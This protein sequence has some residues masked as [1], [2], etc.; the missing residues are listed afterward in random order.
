MLCRM[1]FFLNFNRKSS[2]GFTLPAW[3]TKPGPV[4]LRN[5]VRAN[6]N[7]DH[8]CQVQLT[9]ANPILRGSDFLTAMNLP[10]VIARFSPLPLVLL[11]ISLKVWK[12]NGD[13]HQ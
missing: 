4:L 6:K 1:N 5:I 12:S 8:D 7:D 9:E 11:V 2:N 10:W 3:L 13:G